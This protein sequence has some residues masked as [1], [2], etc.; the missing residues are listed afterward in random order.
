MSAADVAAHE[1]GSFVRTS[2]EV[3]RAVARY[4]TAALR[5]EELAGL[6]ARNMT[7]AQFDSLALAQDTMAESRQV[8]GQAGLLHLVDA[9]SAVAK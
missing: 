5:V 1:A 8:L 2:P 9:G 3:Q 7:G 4:E 6:D